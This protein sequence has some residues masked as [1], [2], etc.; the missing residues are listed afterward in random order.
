MSASD[1]Q[2]EENGRQKRS[3]ELDRYRNELGD[4]TS[5]LTPEVTQ[6]VASAIRVGTSFDGSARFGGISRD[7]F[8]RWLNAGRRDDAPEQLAAFAREVDEA[9]A[10]WEVDTMRR[11]HN[12]PSWQSDAWALERRR[13]DSY[14]RRVRLDGNVTSDPRLGEI[15][16]ALEAHALQPARLTEAEFDTF[17]ELL[18]KMT[19]PEGD[20]IELEPRQRALGA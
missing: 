3:G 16:K 4:Y 8:Y 14:G 7:T 15:A 12:D 20:I 1:T 17:K 19:P 2:Q 18:D 9:F 11:I 10:A 6:R 5:K 13:P